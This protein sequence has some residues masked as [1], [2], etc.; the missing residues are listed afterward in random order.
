MAKASPG[1]LEAAVM[2]VLWDQG[3]PMTVRE[4]LD[5]VN[6]GRHR[7]LAYTTVMTTLA[8]L[9]DKGAVLR[10][11]AGRGYSYRPAGR[12]PAALAVRSVLT[13]HGDAAIAHFV[14]QVG[15][16]PE[17]LGRLR[18]LLDARPDEGR[19]GG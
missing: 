12:D 10:E 7:T 5:A 15:A 17:Q 14:E 3:A 2:K 4:V 16:D 1:G 13:D 18:R 6:E 19:A 9:A 11:A 8:R